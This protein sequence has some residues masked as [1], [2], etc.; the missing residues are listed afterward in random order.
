ME[1]D[2]VY[3]IIYHDFGIVRYSTIPEVLDEGESCQASP[4]VAGPR[5]P[6]FVR[7]GIFPRAIIIY[8]TVILRK[9]DRI[10]DRSVGE[11]TIIRSPP[12][13]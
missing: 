7:A 13:N 4:S 11:G 10:E 12:F 3:Y 1:R 6:F 9:I 5:S 2:T 8:P